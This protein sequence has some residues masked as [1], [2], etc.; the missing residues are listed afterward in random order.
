MC[1]SV[2]ERITTQAVG[3]QGTLS[4][5]NGGREHF[6]EMGAGRQLLGRRCWLST[7][8]PRLFLLA[9]KWDASRCQ[10]CWLSCHQDAKNKI[11]FAKRGAIS[12]IVLRHFDVKL[13]EERGRE[14]ERVGERVVDVENFI[15]SLLQFGN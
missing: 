3:H 11:H 2:C 5:R 10:R 15:N 4:A 8:W 12:R 14:R 6:R 7:P 1:V 13:A 9:P